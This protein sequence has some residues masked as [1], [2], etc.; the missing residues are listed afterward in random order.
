M[1]CIYFVN[2]AFLCVCVGGGGGK[3]CTVDGFDSSV[4]TDSLWHDLVLSFN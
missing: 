2:S 4:T 3:E 1:L